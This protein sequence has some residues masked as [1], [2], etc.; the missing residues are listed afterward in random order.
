[1]SIL[2][3]MASGRPV[4]STNIGGA[5]QLVENG[6]NGFLVSPGNIEELAGR[7]IELLENDGTA[8]RMGK[9]G[10]IKASKYT[11]SHTADLIENAYRDCVQSTT[12]EDSI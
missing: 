4:I 10:Q 12:C 9:N 11:I 6:H 5:R 3:A 8:I 7:I 2:E 1:M